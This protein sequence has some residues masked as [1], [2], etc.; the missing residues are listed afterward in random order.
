LRR[1]VTP[2]PDRFR[3]ADQ[4]QFTAVG[5]PTLSLSLPSTSEA[6]RLARLAVSQLPGIDAARDDVTLVVSE[7]VTNAVTHA[8]ARAEDPITLEIRHEAG[9]LLIDVRDAGRSGDVPHVRPADQ[10]GDGGFGLVLVGRLARDWDS[11]S[12][13]EN[14]CV[15]R[16]RMTVPCGGA[17]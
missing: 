15:V 4:G 13:T 14:G 12:S 7:L 6:P 9:Q 8:G 17:A 2:W 3:H 11:V 16:V 1:I 10:R 5:D